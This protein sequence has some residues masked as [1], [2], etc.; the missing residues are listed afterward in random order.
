MT[1]PSHTWYTLSPNETPVNGPAKVGSPFQTVSAAI[2]DASISGT[3]ENND[4][5][6]RVLFGEILHTLLIFQIHVAP[7]AVQTKHSV[8]EDNPQCLPTCTKRDR[9]AWNFVAVTDD[10]D[11]FA[12]E[13]AR[14][15]APFVVF[16][17][18]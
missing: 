11:L 8:A 9:R 15:P 3:Q 17:N 4:V 10:D 12:F 13:Y 16:L 1:S 18:G 5:L 2:P 7:A 14:Y 6:R